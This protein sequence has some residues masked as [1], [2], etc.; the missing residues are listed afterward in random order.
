MAA[1]VPVEQQ[2]FAPPAPDEFAGQL[3]IGSEWA[4]TENI[5]KLVETFKDPAVQEFLRTDPSVKD[6]LLPL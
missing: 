5:T 1:K 2:I 6:I 3:T 4:D